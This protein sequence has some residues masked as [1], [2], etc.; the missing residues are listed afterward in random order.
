MT[1]LVQIPHLL[2]TLLQRVVKY[3]ALL[4]NIRFKDIIIDKYLR[5]HF[6][7]DVT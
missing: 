4:S 3:V 5:G 6:S 7:M 2:L 1:P